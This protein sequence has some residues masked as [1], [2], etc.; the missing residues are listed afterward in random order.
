MY[1]GAL[2]GQ[3]ALRYRQTLRSAQQRMA[4]QERETAT[5]MQ[6]GAKGIDEFNAQVRKLWDA[7]NTIPKEPQ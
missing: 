6:A 3:D 7:R 5:R 2:D 1:Q 4:D